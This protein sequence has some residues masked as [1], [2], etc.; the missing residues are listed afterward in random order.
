L[1]LAYATQQ[2]EASRADSTESALLEIEEGAPLLRCT[3]TV[4]GPEDV[5]LEYATGVYRG[6][7]YK[8][9]LRL[10]GATVAGGIV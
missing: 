10:E 4:Y 1:D 6:D 5:V 3:R 8:Y 9:R 7:R 2:I